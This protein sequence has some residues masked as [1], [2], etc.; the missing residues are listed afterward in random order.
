MARNSWSAPLQFHHDN[1]S[2]GVIINEIF[3]AYFHYWEDHSHIQR[4]NWWKEWTSFNG[5]KRDWGKEWMNGQT[6]GWTDGWIDWWIQIFA[7]GTPLAIQ[8][9]L[10]FVLSHCAMFIALWTV[11]FSFRSLWF[12]G[13]RSAVSRAM[14]VLTTNHN[15]F[16]WRTVHEALFNIRMRGEKRLYSQTHL[17]QVW[18]QSGIW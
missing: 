7:V 12:T 9:L 8:E 16:H 5:D 1:W 14:L 18:F 6:S 2:T 11:R 13:N 10:L 4:E 17:L 3:Q 15:G